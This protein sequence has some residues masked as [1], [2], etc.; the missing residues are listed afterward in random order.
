MGR[1]RRRA[2]SLSKEGFNRVFKDNYRSSGGGLTVLSQNSQAAIAR[3]GLAVSKK[4]LPRAVD[5]N[6]IKRLIRES[7]RQHQSQIA[8]H[9]V[10]VMSLPGL[11]G[12]SN[13]QIFQA[14]GRH[15]Q[16]LN[17]KQETRRPSTGH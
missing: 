5:R 8:G 1:F 17:K 12:R 4:H 7:F 6:R 15:W 3:L 11:A 2:R 16:Q 13:R 10:V 9:N 14:L